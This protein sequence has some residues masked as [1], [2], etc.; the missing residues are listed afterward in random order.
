VTELLDIAGYSVE[1]DGAPILDRVTLAIAPGQSLGLVGESGCGKSMTA[2]SVLGLL[3]G[4]A[5]VTGGHVRLNG[6]RVDG[7]DDAALRRL[8]GGVAAMIFQEPSACLNP[9]MRIGAQIAEMLDL[10]RELPRAAWDDEIRSLLA[11]TGLADP[12]RTARAWPHQLS[13]GMQQRAMIAMALAGHP[14]LLIADEPTTALDARIGRQILDLIDSLRRE[15]GLGL[16]MIS[17]DLGMVAGYCERI[18]VMYA[19][20]VVEEASAEEL[21]RRPAHPYTQALLAASP[22]LNLQARKAELA[23]IPGQLPPPGSRGLGCGFADRCPHAAPACHAG[24]P[25][26]REIAPGHRVRC[27]LHG[28]A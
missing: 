7:A 28:E 19:G 13:G 3:P 23:D 8:R 16:L 18:A 1:I 20:R 11:A 6:Q 14:E 25:G 4:R 21:F 5:R 2:L 26:L 17:H 24:D 9:V 10:H 22:G 27:I 15:R 12:A